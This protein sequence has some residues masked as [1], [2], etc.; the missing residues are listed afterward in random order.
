MGKGEVEGRGKESRDRG[1]LGSR[2][3]LVFEGAGRAARGLL[4]TGRLL[5]DDRVALVIGWREFGQ[6]TQRS[7]FA[8]LA[9]LTGVRRSTRMR[10]L[11]LTWSVCNL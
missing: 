8:A 4:A 2:V 7:K 11:S 6:V 3:P 10:K 9:T 5:D 1:H